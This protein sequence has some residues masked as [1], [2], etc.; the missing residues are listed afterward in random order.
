MADA[1][2]DA[3]KRDIDLRQYAAS[4]GYEWDRR[5]S[6]RGSTVMRSAGDKVVIKRNANGHYV[7]FSVKDDADNGTIIDFIQKRHRC[8]LGMVRIELRPWIG[9]PVS[10]ALPL[11]PELEKSSTDRVKVEAAY[12]RMRDV[13]ASPY[14][15]SRGLPPALFT[16]ERFAGRIRVDDRRNVA[17]AHYDEAGLCGFE[18][19]NKNFTG[20]ASGGEKG[21]WLSAEREDDTRLVICEG[22]IDAL[23]HA[24]LF[25][26]PTARYASVGGKLNPVQPA[27]VAHALARLPRGAACVLATDADAPGREL[28]ATLRRA[29]EAVLATR[30]DL[31]VAEHWPADGFKDW[32]DQVQAGRS[33][34]TTSPIHTR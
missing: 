26:C 23:S 29:C 10:P 17:F 12:A 25:P 32:N 18:L 28:A 11:F 7:Y 21:L 34:E 5:E 13:T 33:P 2:L 22:A 30:P 4:Q 6:W 16:A 31:T 14:L 20:F 8:S 9:K 15:E 1:E 19:K 3:F 27:L 24:L